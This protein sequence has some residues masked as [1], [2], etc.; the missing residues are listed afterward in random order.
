MSEDKKEKI[1]A[2]LEIGVL[3]LLEVGFPIILAIILK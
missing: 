3:F 2:T 1:K